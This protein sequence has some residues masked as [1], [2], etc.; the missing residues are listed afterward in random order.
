MRFF[1]TVAAELPLCFNSLVAGT[2]YSSVHRIYGV[3]LSERV[4][5]VNT[6]FQKNFMKILSFLYAKDSGS[7]LSPDYFR[8]FFG[9]FCRFNTGIVI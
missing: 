8:V 3:I 6:V 4:Y 9:F 7:P 5:I 2:E 1:R